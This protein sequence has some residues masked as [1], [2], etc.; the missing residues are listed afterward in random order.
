MIDTSKSGGTPEPEASA[1]R[2]SLPK[3]AIVLVVIALF[4]G[5]VAAKVLTSR[6]SANTSSQPTSSVASVHND[7][8]ADY[9]AALKE[10]KP[11]YVLFHSLS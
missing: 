1:P 6:T 7:A 10:G 2:N 5:V 9:Q 4:S 11:I 3:I 8:I